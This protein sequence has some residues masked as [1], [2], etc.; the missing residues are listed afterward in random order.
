MFK[1]IRN[2][3]DR[4]KKRI[5][6]QHL[7]EV[8]EQEFNTNMAVVEKF[9]EDYPGELHKLCKVFGRQTQSRLINQWQTGHLAG[10][11]MDL[12]LAEWDLVGPN[13]EMASHY[14]REVATPRPLENANDIILPSPFHAWRLG[15]GFRDIGHDKAC[16]PWE[17]KANH[18]VEYWM[19]MGVGWVSCGN[20]SL[21]VGLIEGVGSIS[22]YKA[23]DMSALYD[24]VY[25]DG[26]FYK[27]TVD[28]TIIQP[29]RDVS[30]GTMF[31]IG[32]IISKTPNW[33]L[34]QQESS[35]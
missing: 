32:R 13:D 1:C 20:H 21:T 34:S 17:E 5:V 19:P 33:L 22:N 11:P 14:L 2:K 8:R 16:G 23:Y 26:S 6:R 29:V 25:C 30:I 10:E 7:R 28:D 9:R 12:F 24:H 3:I 4:V 15:R 27:R 35:L 18:S 31:E